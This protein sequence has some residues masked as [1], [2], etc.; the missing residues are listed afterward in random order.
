MGGVLSRDGNGMGLF[1]APPR[2][3]PNRTGLGAWLSGI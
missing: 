3:V 2:P 1:D